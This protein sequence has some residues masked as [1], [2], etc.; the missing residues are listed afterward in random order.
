TASS[1]VGGTASSGVGGSPTTT[2]SGVGGFPTTSS[3]GAGGA[4]PT[5]SSGVGGSPG[6]SGCAD[7]LLNGTGNLCPQSAVLFQQVVDC[8]CSYGCSMECVNECNGGPWGNNCDGC[9]W[10][11]C[12]PEID[13]C[14]MDQ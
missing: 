11:V 5:M 10:N 7:A 8:A 13:Q 3:S 14:L 12:L 1:G 4:P 6:C 2:S 9:F